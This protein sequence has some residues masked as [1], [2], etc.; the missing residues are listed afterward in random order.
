MY[1]QYILERTDDLILESKEGFATYR[2]MNDGKAVYIIDIFVLPQHRKEGIAARLAD[3]IVIEAKAKG[4]TE[5]LGSVVPSTKNS[6]ISMQVLV[7]Y[8]M[9]LASSSNDFVVFRRDI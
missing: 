8:G 3:Q 1:A 6:T 4:A 2:Y 5:L 7:G 9:T